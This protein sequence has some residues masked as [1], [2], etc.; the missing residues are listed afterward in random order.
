MKL[1]ISRG[2][3]ERLCAGLSPIARAELADL[4][5][6]YPDD[7]EQEFVVDQ[8]R[9]GSAWDK[10]TR[11]DLVLDVVPTPVLTPWLKQTPTLGPWPV[12]IDETHTWR[13]VGHVVDDGVTL[14]AE[15]VGAGPQ[16]P[17]PWE[18]LAENCWVAPAGTP[19]PWVDAFD[20]AASQYV[21]DRVS[22]EPGNPLADLREA[23]AVFE[24][25]APPTA[26]R[27]EAGDLAVTAIAALADGDSQDKAWRLPGELGDLT[28]V[29]VVR[30]SSLTPNAWR[31][32][33]VHSGDVVLEGTAGPSIDRFRA[34]IDQLVDDMAE[35]YGI[36]RDLLKPPAPDA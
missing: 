30:N 12:I 3:F 15:D 26:R 28:G 20:H 11:D 27:L 29:P 10:L 36:P 9:I 22:E 18:L 13:D 5:Q 1:W 23:F 35:E 21:N 14:F 31:L 2:R 4:V 33:D 34:V 16:L 19:P 25:K 24:C 8:D 32:V 7:V 17:P 6:L